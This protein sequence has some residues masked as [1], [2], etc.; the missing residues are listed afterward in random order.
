MRV[1][2]WLGWQGLVSASLA[3]SLV[4]TLWVQEIQVDARRRD[5]I[6]YLKAEVAKLDLEVGEVANLRDAIAELL[7]RKAIIE[8]LRTRRYEVR[9][10]E[11]IATRRPRGV[12]L[13]GLRQERGQFFL[14]GFAASERDAAAFV[15][16]L[17]ASP[18]LEEARLLETAAKAVAPSSAFPVRFVASTTLKGRK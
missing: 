8:S 13:S 7:A 15:A 17:N 18:L 4:L 16:N 2:R 11:E 1:L 9:L 3:L 12:Y 10:L 6:Q 14:S 5:H